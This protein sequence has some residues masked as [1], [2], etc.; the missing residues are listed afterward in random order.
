MNEESFLFF[1]LGMLTSIIAFFIGYKP[2]QFLI[3]VIAIE[4]G[5]L[6]GVLIYKLYEKNILS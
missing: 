4:L 5:I 6:F 3:F 2:K 1:V